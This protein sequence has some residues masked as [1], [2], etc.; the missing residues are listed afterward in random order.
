MPCTWPRLRRTGAE[1]PAPRIVDVSSQPRPAGPPRRDPPMTVRAADL[2]LRD[3]GLDPRPRRTARDKGAHELA[4][5]ADVVKVEHP[6]IGLVA[7]DA[8]VLTEIVGHQ[9]LR[10]PDPPLPRHGGLLDVLRAAPPEVVAE[11]LPAPVLQPRPGPVEGRR[12]EV[13]PAAPTQLAIDQHEH[14]FAYVPDGWM[15]VSCRA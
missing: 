8:R 2:A 15:V 11:A 3:L 4:F 6:R 9:A 1:N 13:P 10:E 5:L 12:R 7:V 14:M